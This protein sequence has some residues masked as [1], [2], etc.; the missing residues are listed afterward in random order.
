LVSQSVSQSVN[1]EGQTC[2]HTWILKQLW[3]A[4]SKDMGVQIFISNTKHKLRDTVLRD[5]SSVSHYFSSRRDMSHSN[6][7]ARKI[8]N[9]IWPIGPQRKM[10]PVITVLH[11]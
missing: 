5:S 8:L 3:I 1:G 2:S 10:S 7:A 6:A 4:D 11:L 9:P